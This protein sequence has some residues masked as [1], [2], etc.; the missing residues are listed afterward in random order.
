MLLLFCKFVYKYG[1]RKCKRHPKEHKSLSPIVPRWRS[2]NWW[3]CW[4]GGLSCFAH[5]GVLNIWHLLSA[6]FEIVFFVDLAYS[7]G[8]SP[9]GHSNVNYV[10]ASS[11]WKEEGLRVL[12]FLFG[13]GKLMSPREILTQG[14]TTNSPPEWCSQICFL[15]FLLRLLLLSVRSL[16]WS[17]ELNLPWQEAPHLMGCADLKFHWRCRPEYLHMSR[18]HCTGIYSLPISVEVKWNEGGR[19]FYRAF[20]GQ[21][22]HWFKSIVA[23]IF[24]EAVRGFVAD[25]N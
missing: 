7:R 12:L 16:K 19:C 24:L 15:W 9:Q 6:M 25:G 18:L 4:W 17:A 8:P 23:P 20:T 21:N 10:D 3:L 11:H 2:S 14:R 13:S 5:R 1:Y 22:A